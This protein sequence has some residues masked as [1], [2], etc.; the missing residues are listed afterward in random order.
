M[1]TGIPVKKNGGRNEK[2]R[3][4]GDDLKKCC[5]RSG[6]RNIK[7]VCHSATGLV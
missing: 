1:M 3:R 2:L 4:M 7:V 6:R 5:C